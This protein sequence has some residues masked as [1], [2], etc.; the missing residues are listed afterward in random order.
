MQHLFSPDGEAALAAVLRLRPLMA[1]D[2]DGTLAPI[3]ARPDDCLLYTSPSP[4]D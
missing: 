2:F 4:R 3:V 1:F